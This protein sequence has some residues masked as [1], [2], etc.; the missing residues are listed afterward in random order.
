M[1]A[2]GRRLGGCVR[3]GDTVAR[4]GGGEFVVLLRTGSEAVG[5]QAVGT[6]ER[7]RA[8]LARPF[9]VAGRRLTMTSS[10]GVVSDVRGYNRPG[11]VCATRISPCTRLKRPGGHLPGV[12]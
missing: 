3:G 4:F 9:R 2:F 5:E 12:H 11:D 7:I 6:A 1:R 8:A 10:I